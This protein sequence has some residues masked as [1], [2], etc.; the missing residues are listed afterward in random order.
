MYIW[1]KLIASY[2]AKY[3]Q[4][5]GLKDLRENFVT[6]LLNDEKSLLYP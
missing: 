5:S 4:H 2:F 1:Q 6:S 3:E